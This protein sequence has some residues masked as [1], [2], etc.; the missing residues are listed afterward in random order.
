M[1]THRL[2]LHV[3]PVLFLGLTACSSGSN[4]PA[5]QIQAGL[6]DVTSVDGNGNTSISDSALATQLSLLPLGTLSDLEAA[7]ILYMREEEKLAR[8][9]YVALG[10]QWGQLIFSNIAARRT[11]LSESDRRADR[12]GGNRGDR[13]HRYRHAP[14]RRRRQ[15]RYRARL[16]EPEER[17]AQSSTRIRQKPGESRLFLSAAV[18][19]QGSVRGDHQ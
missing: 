13:H 6:P 11:R 8:D 7:G 17:V 5:P 9:V 2:S 16:R 18:S 15:C 10:D 4:G 12:R 14:G 3:L 1:L 19:D